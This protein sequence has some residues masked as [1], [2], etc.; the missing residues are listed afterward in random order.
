MRILIEIMV[1]GKIISEINESGELFFIDGSKVKRCKCE[2]E[3]VCNSCKKSSIWNSIP[4]K[5]YLTKKEFLC[6]SCRQIGEK[7][8]QYGKKWKEDRKIEKSNQMSGEKNHMFGKS[9][10]DI[11]LEKYGEEESLKLLVEH[12]NKSRK[13]G[14]ENGMFAKSF[15][16]VWLDRYGKDVADKKLIEFKLNKVKWLSENPEHH[17]NMIINSHIRR[18]RKTSIEKKVESYLKEIN[19]DFKYNFILDNLYQ[20]DFFIKD[21]NLIIETHG[22]YWHANPLYYSDSDYTKKK[23]NETQRY[24]VNLDNLKLEYVV[25]K[26]YRLLS[27]WETDIKNDNYKKILKNYGIY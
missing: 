12:K 16:D 11:W 21:M 24:K 3:I 26:K 10:Y 25:E 17:K 20:F 15:Y 4:A 18:Y 23:L 9:F 7:N 13:I 5:E 8:N 1:D 2:V 22:D 6:K 14:Q 19:I 27:I